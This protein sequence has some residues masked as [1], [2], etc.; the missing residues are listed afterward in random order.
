MIHLKS[1]EALHLKNYRNYMRDWV[2]LKLK[3][4][5]P[6]QKLDHWCDLVSIFFIADSTLRPTH[7]NRGDLAVSRSRL[8]ALTCSCFTSKVQPQKNSLNSIF[9]LISCSIDS[10]AHVDTLDWTAH[11]GKQ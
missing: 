6:K 2:S 5:T 3:T 9:N 4:G 1:C 8:R 7:D 11:S 10:I